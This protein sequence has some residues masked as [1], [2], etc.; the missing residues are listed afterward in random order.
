MPVFPGEA[1]AL[2]RASLWGCTA[3]CQQVRSS[4]F[5]LDGFLNIICIK[6]NNMFFVGSLENTKKHK[7]KRV[8]I[9]PPV[10]NH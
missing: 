4:K 8:L 7:G 10:N 9:P 6:S 1:S 5:S 2:S 3:P